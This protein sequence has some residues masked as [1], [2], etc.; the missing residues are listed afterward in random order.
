MR[1]TSFHIVACLL[2]A[3]VIAGCS[4][5]TTAP[6]N[7]PGFLAVRD[8]IAFG[9]VANGQTRD[10][11]IRI[12]NT[13]G[14]NLTITSEAASSSAVVD[15]NFRQPVV[16]APGDYR[17]ISI[18]FSP[19]G[20]Q[21]AYDSIKYQTD[22]K[23][24][25]ATITLVANG[26]SNGGG[27]GSSL[28]LLV[29]NSINFGSIPV[30]QWH[31]TTLFLV[32]GGTSPIVITSAVMSGGEGK[33]T[34]AMPVILTSGQTRL[35]HVA[36]NPSQA[37]PR[38]VTDQI[39]YVS[40]GTSSAVT[41]TI[42]ANGTTSGG[43]G[44]TGNAPGPGSTFTFDTWQVDTN[45]I[46][47]PHSDS[48][49]TIVSNSLTIHGKSNV[50]AVRGPSGDVTYYHVESN[51]DLS[52]YVDFSNIS[53]NGIPVSAFLSSN[54]FVIPL[55]SRSAINQTL[56]DTSITYN[57]FPVQLT[58]TEAGSYL[59]SPTVMAA[60]KSFATAMGS[61]KFS[62]KISGLGGLLSITNS[63]AF[64]IWYSRT[65]GFYPERQDVNTSS[66]GLG[67]SA[68]TTSSNYLLKSYQIH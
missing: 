67:Q 24:A 19:S 46:A 37:G 60:G 40:N 44:G 3:G 45:G 35:I 34:T 56:M 65:L 50:M 27:N 6:G 52:V 7:R 14:D 68:Q 32:N 2:I 16:L 58:I 4:S 26:G 48:T 55:G 53:A 11:S 63:L 1:H 39:N 8:T 51:G 10:T 59:G 36:F 15:S 38:V 23:N 49:Y 22:G 62:G 61:L 66:G 41:L 47:G 13:G 29:P 33:D 64:D 5:S 43:G 20:S 18:F 54:W 28:L 9:L 57:G 31:D 25:V 30:G 17:D 21:T 12:S 42:Q